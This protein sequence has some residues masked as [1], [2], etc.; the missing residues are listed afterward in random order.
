M[1]WVD[2]AL[3]LTDPSRSLDA[4]LHA[5]AVAPSKGRNAAGSKTE[6][7][8][9][10]PLRDIL[11]FEAPAAEAEG[12]DAGPVADPALIMARAHS[13]RKR[14][15]LSALTIQLRSSRCAGPGTGAGL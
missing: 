11:G 5:D 9:E 8:A 3:A 10:R 2:P 13:L 7:P 1:V 14:C 6:R 15:P 4:L 12:Q